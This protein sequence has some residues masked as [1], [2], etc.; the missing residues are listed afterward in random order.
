MARQPS[1]GAFRGALVTGAGGSMA[2]Y[3]P[4]RKLAFC[5]LMNQMQEGVV[6]GGTY[7][8]ETNLSLIPKLGRRLGVSSSMRQQTVTRT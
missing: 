7:L 6:T 2:Y 5:F 4:E 3:D 1:N 8:E